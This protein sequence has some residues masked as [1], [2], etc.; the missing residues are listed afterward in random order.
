MDGRRLPWLPGDW[1]QGLKLSLGGN[2]I[3]VF[4]SPEGKIFHNRRDVEKEVGRTLENIEKAPEKEKK[5][6]KKDA[7]P[8]KD[9]PTW[10]PADWTMG[11]RESAGVPRPYYFSPGGQGFFNRQALEAFLLK[12]GAARAPAAPEA[13]RR[14]P[15]AEERRTRRSQAAAAAAPPE[16]AGAAAPGPEPAEAAPGPAEAAE[17]AA[18]RARAGEGGTDEE[19]ETLCE[20]Q[21]G[22][23]YASRECRGGSA[24]LLLPDA[25]VSLDLAAVGAQVEAA[26]WRCSARDEQRWSFTGSPDLVLYPSGK[27]LVRSGKREDVGRIARQYVDSWLAVE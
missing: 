15:A 3:R 25:V 6:K 24:W 17:P 5:D 18:K 7:P 21:P 11:A 2:K 10:L 22:E 9:W 14:P 23:G 16:P 1:G 27:M 20:G 13:R 19:L 12:G 26:G 4:L 8:R